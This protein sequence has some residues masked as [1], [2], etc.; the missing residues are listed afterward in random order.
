MYVRVCVYMC[1]YAVH[2]Y[3]KYAPTCK[4]V[5]AHV[6][7]STSIKTSGETRGEDVGRRMSV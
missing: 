4:T 6:H 3:K 5:N 2:T 1:I 7:I